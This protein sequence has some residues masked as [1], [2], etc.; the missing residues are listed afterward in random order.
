MIVQAINIGGDVDTH[1]FDL[2]I[3]GGGVGAFNGCSTQWGTADLGAQYGGFATTCG[4]NVS[5]V[6]DRCNKTFAG[7][8]D[9]LAGCTWFTTWFNAANNP[10]IKYAEVACPQ[11]ITAKS[12]M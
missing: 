12:G 11:A 4:T 1:Q 9:L 5:C 7:K 2:L 10:K 8:A 3:P 6:T